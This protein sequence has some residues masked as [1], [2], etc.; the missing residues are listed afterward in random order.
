[1]T[2]DVAAH[3]GKRARVNRL[4]RAQ[5]AGSAMKPTEPQAVAI[6]RIQDACTTGDCGCFLTGPPGSGKTVTA[7]CAMLSMGRNRVV[8]IVPSK[9]GTIAQQW[10][11][12]VRRVLPP[13]NQSAQILTL[14]EHGPSTADQLDAWRVSGNKPLL[15]EATMV[16][17]TTYTFLVAAHKSHPEIVTGLEAVEWDGVVLDEAHCLRNGDNAFDKK[18]VRVFEAVR[19]FVERARHRHP[20][21]T[22]L[23]VSATPDC[24]SRHGYMR[25][26]AHLMAPTAFPLAPGGEESDGEE[27]DDEESPDEVRNAEACAT[28]WRGHVS[29]PWQNVPPTAAMVIPYTMSDAEIRRLVPRL[30]SFKK[31][32]SVCVAT[33]A[34]KGERKRV[35]LAWLMQRTVLNQA[36]MLPPL[37]AAREEHGAVEEAAEFARAHVQS[38][39]QEILADFGECGLLHAVHGKLTEATVSPEE[40]RVLVTCDFKEPLRVLDAK[41]ACSG[42]RVF[43]LLDCPSNG[44][45][46]EEIERFRA[47]VPGST[48]RRAVL[49]TTSQRIKEGTSRPR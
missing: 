28:F 6:Q 24:D 27:S 32:T 37:L 15:R 21:L 3:P 23:P 39:L 40:Q 20:S 41:L 38:H 16:C 45:L 11:A 1:M 30:R 43:S 13:P 44:R 12:T 9:G 46:C 49:L 42:V 25:A 19:E 31:L 48:H 22:V 29:L 26:V 4:P 14:T 33:R 7:M 17:I 5:A 8:V 18:P 47:F 36:A 35:M 2:C 10:D 34:R